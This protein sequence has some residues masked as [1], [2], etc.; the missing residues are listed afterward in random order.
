M[1][2]LGRRVAVLEQPVHTITSTEPEESEESTLGTLRS[3]LTVIENPSL[4]GRLGI[5]M[6]EKTL[7][8]DEYNAKSFFHVY[9]IRAFGDYIDPAI[10]HV[11][12]AKSENVS[13]GRNPPLYVV[14]YQGGG[15]YAVASQVPH[16][17]CKITDDEFRRFEATL[18]SPQRVVELTGLVNNMMRLIGERTGFAF[19]H[20]KLVVP[21]EYAS[22]RL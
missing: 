22:T 7:L 13:K 19:E 5:L 21:P 6:A 20:G 4:D 12:I 15:R 10:L 2:L 14:S 1:V 18:T 17:I 3:S 11:D 9:V 8:H 16:E